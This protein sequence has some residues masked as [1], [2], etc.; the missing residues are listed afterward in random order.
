MNPRQRER[1]EEDQIVMKRFAPN[2][3]EEEFKKTESK[4]NRMV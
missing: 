1:E 2:F 4:R 3:S